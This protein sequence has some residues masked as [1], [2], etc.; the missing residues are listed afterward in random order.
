LVEKELTKAE[1]KKGYVSKAWCPICEKWAYSSDL[2]FI[3]RHQH[4]GFSVN[5]K[6]KKK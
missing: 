6:W 1:K 4:V 2:K 5:T 3:P